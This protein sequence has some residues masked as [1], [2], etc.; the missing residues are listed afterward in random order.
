MVNPTSLSLRV[1]TPARQVHRMPTC[2]GSVFVSAHREADAGFERIDL[3]AEF[4]ARKH[5][6]RLDAQH[7]ERGESH[8]RQAIVLAPPATRRPTRLAAASG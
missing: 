7:V 4:G 1:S 6:P 3:I 2:K 8:R 5:E